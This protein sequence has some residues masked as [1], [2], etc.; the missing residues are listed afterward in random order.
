MRERVHAPQSRGAEG[1]TNTLGDEITPLPGKPELTKGPSGE[2]TPRPL[3]HG[4]VATG[5]AVCSKG[6][7]G[8][9]TP[10]P[11]VQPRLATGLA[12]C[13]KGPSGEWTPRPLVQASCPETN[14]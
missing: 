10:R 7:S 4:R 13:S 6:P 12:V 3:V 14:A 1:G 11:L 8:E 5:L 9:W 2:W